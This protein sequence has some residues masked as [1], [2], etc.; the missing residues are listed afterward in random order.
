MAVMKQAIE[1][2][3]RDHGIAEHVPPFADRS[4]GRDQ[5]AAPFVTAA[6]QLEEQ[7]RRFRLER[8]ITQLVDDQQLGLGEVGDPLV[9]LAVGIGFGELRDQ[10]RRRYE[11]HGVAGQ[12]R[13]APDRDREVRLADAGRSS[14]TMPGVRRLACGSGTVSIPAAEKASSFSAASV[15]LAPIT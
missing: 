10:D 15:T 12:D 9:E 5:N 4:I 7:M 2:R 8:E 14:V 6:D 13:R 3:G 11:E 1:D